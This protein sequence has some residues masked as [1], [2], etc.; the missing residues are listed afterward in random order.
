MRL[1]L[2]I[3]IFSDFISISTT[4]FAASSQITGSVKDARSGD[5]LP[6]ANIL[7]VGTSLG[8][9]TDLNGNFSILE[10]PSGS[11]MLRASYVGYK[12]YET[13][14]NVEEGKT[15]KLNL[16]LL[17]VGVRG[18]E[19]MVMAQASGQNQAI[20]QQLS[21]SN[22]V[23]V[24]SAARIQELP[25]ANAAE[26]L[27]RLPGMSV[28]RS[29]GEAD[30]I[31]IRG[32]APKYNRIMINGVQLT[33]SNQNDESVDLSM[34][35]SNML[36]GMEVKKTVTPDM[37]ANVIGGTVN[38]ELREAH[39][40]IPGVPVFG[41]LAQGG[42]DALSDA[43]NKLSNYKYV[44]SIEDRFFHERLGVF[45]QADVERKN[46]SSNQLG[47]SYT[48]SGNSVTQYLTTS[49]N[50][51]DMPRDR[52]R[53]DGALVIDYRL[54]DGT[55]KFSNFLS[56][57]TTDVA[58]RGESYGV[59]SNTH[60]YTLN[61][62]S[63]ALSVMTDALHLEYQ[64]PVFHLNAEIS[65]A[66]TQT[67]DPQDWTVNFQQGSAGLGSLVNVT[68]LNPLN[69]LQ[70]AHDSAQ[71]TYL[72]SLQ[73]SSTYSG[74]RAFTGSL[75]L[76]ANL[77]FSDFITS[78]IKFG[79]TYR[80]ERRIYAYGE[81]VGG[82]LGYTASY[83]IDSLITSHLKIPSQYIY[84]GTD[85]MMV[86]FI[87]PNYSYGNFLGGS[88]SMSYPL[89]FG[90]LSDLTN[91]LS[92]DA[93]VYIHDTF[94]STTHNYTGH[95]NQGAAFVMATINFG[96]QV[97]V[98][99]GVRFQSLQT[100][101]TAPQGQ[102][103]TSSSLGGPYL[104][105][106]TT[107]TAE[108]GYWL[109]DIALRYKPISWFDLRLSYTH[110]LAYP[111]FEAIIPRIDVPPSVGGTISW[112]NTQLTPSRSTNYDAQ[113]S[114]Y[115]NS[116]GLL[117][118]GGFLKKIDGLIYPWTF[119]VS[120]QNVL[121]YYP[122]GLHPVSAPTG[123]YRIATYV[124]DANRA[125]DYGLELDWETHFWYLPHPFDG[126]VLDIN[127]THVFSNEIYPYTT[128][129][130]VGRNVFYVDTSFTDRLLYQPDNI[131]NLSVGY[132]YEGF[133]VRVSMIYQDNIFYGTNFWPQLRIT[134]SAYGRWDVSAKQDLPWYGLQLYGDLSNIN[135]ENDVYVI[136]AATGVPQSEQDYGMNADF[137]LRVNF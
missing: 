35:S 130:K 133:S 34:I 31:V 124:N 107:V 117:T 110:T 66:Y 136:Q 4:A 99:G 70:V 38:L 60:G 98:V 113:L 131:A 89:N 125:T 12:T 126:L 28:L 39:V 95:E 97:N 121:P 71:G 44:A 129:E 22:I 8:A 85:I 26:S 128:V 77:D 3:L 59:A 108:H 2:M 135:G 53:Y 36:E 94:G 6:G 114:F 74:A 45:I 56:S 87:D 88:Y 62:T 72:T 10:V 48:N 111:D 137:G 32:I 11:Y 61:Y 55:I 33:S 122:A 75:D 127:Y 9:S 112:N 23:N 109:P 105:Y 116:I 100:L 51:D 40:K 96:P 79:G 68:N 103:N 86:P 64:F 90:M 63:S 134:E 27:G 43:N 5:P 49:L 91:Y 93:S 80:Y 47:A 19:V 29:G 25:D 123:T 67:R 102:E 84:S 57:G 52:Q 17:A 118:I 24:V 54:P 50:L 7:L 106:D 76:S 30:E 73:T 78:V 104:H 115:D 81:N 46:L 13:N 41:L 16:K 101:Y 20:N 82:G 37:D 65:H 92:N 83:F 132:D 120:G 69:I 15:L 18:K 1:F 42:Y 14:V 58:D 21:S 119:Y